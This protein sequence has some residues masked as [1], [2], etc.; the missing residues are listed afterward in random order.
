MS[1]KKLIE[2]KDYWWD[3][4]HTTPKGSKVVANIIYTDLLKFLEK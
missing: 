2:K 1:L 4:I 3:G